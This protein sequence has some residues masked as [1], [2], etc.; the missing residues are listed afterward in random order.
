MEQKHRDQLK[1]FAEKEAGQPAKPN[2]EEL[3]A[4]DKA[5]RKDE[6]VQ[7]FVVIYDSFEL[8]RSVSR[9]SRL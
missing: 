9:S 6:N 7:L 8:F 3:P 1:A 2:S 5:L 4:S